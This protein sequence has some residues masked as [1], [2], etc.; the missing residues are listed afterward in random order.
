MDTIFVDRRT[1]RDIPAVLKKI[2]TTI[3]RG[4]GVV[5]FAEG[6][7]TNGRSVAPFKSS[8][9]EV[10]AVNRVPVHYASICYAAPSNEVPAEQSIC[11]WGNMTFPDHLFRL[12]QL[13]SFEARV[14]YGPEAIV[15]DDRRVLAANLWSAVCSQLPPA[16]AQR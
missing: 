11:W 2:E 10:A 14:V 7:S 9:L 15:A 5:L 1:R 4:L 12:L 3:G 8:L 16:I 13:P 6:T